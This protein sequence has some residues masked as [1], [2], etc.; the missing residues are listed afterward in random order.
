MNKLPENF[1]VIDL[2]TSG[3]NPGRHSILKIGAIDAAGRNFYRRC[4]AVRRNG[5]LKRLFGAPRYRYEEEALEVNGI[6]A[7]DLDV[8]MPIGDAIGDLAAWLTDRYPKWLMG[9]KNPQF[10]YN[11]LLAYW[12]WSVWPMSDLI[13]RRTIDLH[14]VVYALNFHRWEDFL[15]PGFKTSQLYRDYDI[16]PEP[17]PHYASAG[18]RH[19]MMCFKRILCKNFEEG[20]L[21]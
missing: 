10:D 5:S 15:T 13:S 3:L 21:R 1:V 18:A 16:E 9:G 11:F 17:R 6:A 12:P 14:Q 8:G 19:T 2:E 7:D 4:Q 20:G